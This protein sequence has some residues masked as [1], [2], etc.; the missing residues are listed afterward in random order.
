VIFNSGATH[1]FI[2]SSFAGL[3]DLVLSSLEKTLDVMSLMGVS[4]RYWKYLLAV[5][6]VIKGHELSVDLIILD[7]T[8]ND[9]ILGMD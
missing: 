4:T 6:V 2:S 8:F 3:L 1:L 7:M 9:V 5:R